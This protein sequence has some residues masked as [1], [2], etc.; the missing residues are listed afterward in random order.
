MAI[1]D[2]RRATK[3][4]VAS[5]T[6]AAALDASRIGHSEAGIWASHRV[7]ITAASAAAVNAMIS[8]P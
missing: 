5:T 3:N 2:P 7:G 6:P 1:V 4:D 8:V